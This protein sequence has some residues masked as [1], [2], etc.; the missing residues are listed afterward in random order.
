VAVA[1]KKVPVKMG[2]FLCLEYGDKNISNILI[3]SQERTTEPGGILNLNGPFLMPLGLLPRI[4]KPSWGV[5]STRPGAFWSVLSAGLF[6]R[7]ILHQPMIPHGPA[8][9]GSAYRADEVGLMDGH[10]I[11]IRGF[12]V[13]EPRPRKSGMGRNIQTGASVDIPKGQSVRF[14]PGKDLRNIEVK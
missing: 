4:R 14:K 1:K 3:A 11:E 9:G 12:G 13:F 5:G 8:G 7:H 10:R 6:H 2:T